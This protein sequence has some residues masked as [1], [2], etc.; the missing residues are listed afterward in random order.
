M[1]EPIRIAASQ[2]TP[3]FSNSVQVA[4][5]HSSKLGATIA[6][7]GAHCRLFSRTLLDGAIDPSPSRWT[8]ETTIATGD[9]CENNFGGPQIAI[10]EANGNIHVFKAVTNSNGATAP[11]ITY[12]RGTPDGTPMLS[13]NISWSSRLVIDSTG[14]NLLEPPDVAGAVDSTGRV[15]VF[16]A[17]KTT[18]GAIKF[19]TLDSPYT[20]P[21]AIGTV[22]TTGSNPR[23]PHVPGLAPLAR[24]Y[25]PLFYET[26]SGSSYS[27]NLTMLDV[28]APTAPTALT[29]TFAPTPEVDLAWT[30]STDNV[31]V[32]GYTIYR[33]G[34]QLTTVSGTTLTYADKAGITIPAT[35]SYTVAASDAAGNMSA[36]SNT[37]TVG[38]VDLV[39]PSVPTGLT[40]AATVGPSVTLNW[41]AST[42][43]VG[44]TG[45]TIYKGGS[46]LMTVSGSTLTYLDTAVVSGGSYSYTVDAYDAAGNHSAKSAPATVN[47]PDTTPPTVPS[48]I[49][50]ST[51]PAPSVSLSWS[52][53]TDNVA[54]TGYTIYRNGAALTTVSA[55]TLTYTDA[56]IARSISYTYALDAFDAAGNHSAK[57]AG[58]VST[59]APSGA[60]ITGKPLAAAFSGDGKSDLA[61]VTASGV[62]VALSNGAAFSTPTTWAPFPF[63]GSVATLAGDVTGDGKADLLAVN[64]GQVFVLPSTGTGFGAPAGWSNVAFYGTR[65]TFLADVNGDGKA[66]LVAVNNTSVWV[67]LSTGTGFS[68]PM[69]WSSTPFYGNL[70]TQIADVTG[71]GKADLVAVNSTSTWVLPSTG[72]GFGA[73]AQWSGVPFYGNVQT[74]LVD[75][76]GDGKVD[77]VALNL[78]STWI[79]TS[80]GSGFGAPTQW[81]ATP[82]YGVIA[83][84]SGDVTGDLKQDLVAINPTSVWVAP[85]TGSALSLPESWL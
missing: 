11:G 4:I 50:M 74:M 40:A 62:F 84:L 38:T 23:Y 51:N 81:E 14:T 35:Y 72:S 58:A 67:M 47:S 56:S 64:A 85:S 8:G 25:V 61:M 9:D 65:G 20:T 73:P 13:G 29:A 63:Y 33:N 82:F 24:G 43:N 69:Q 60:L 83:T 68:A 79:M 22:A 66:D 27:I 26:G 52:G 44:V 53:S 80:T 54:V 59:P 48:G 28:S 17:T 70:S 5:R 3:T 36:L 46:Q 49:S 2:L 77:L 78:T 32:T 15:Y 45:Y 21:S 10:D 34:S 18:G 76:N 75:A 6:V 42:D 37:A 30:A 55:S 16:W 12:W 7:Y 39:A 1:G 31:G 19:V 71:D 57:S 41:T